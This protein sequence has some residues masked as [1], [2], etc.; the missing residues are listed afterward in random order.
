MERDAKA[1][2]RG[3]AGFGRQSRLAEADAMKGTSAIGSRNAQ[4]DQSRHSFRHDT[5]PAGLVD[6]RIVAVSHED[7]ETAHARCDRGGKPDGTTAYDNHI[8]N[9]ASTIGADLLARLVTALHRR[10]IQWDTWYDVCGYERQGEA[11]I[12]IQMEQ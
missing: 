3:K 5:F 11:R 6:G 8:Y 4:R 1:E 12:D 9:L 10:R 7:I 2:A